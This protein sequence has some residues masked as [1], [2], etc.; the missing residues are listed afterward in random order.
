VH[1]EEPRL[2]EIRPRVQLRPQCRELARSGLEP[3]A[4]GLSCSAKL[5]R[6]SG[7]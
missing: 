7:G 3:I 6:L 2:G 5:L 4:Q 1:G